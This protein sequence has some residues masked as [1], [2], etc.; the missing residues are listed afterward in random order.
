MAGGSAAGFVANVVAVVLWRCCCCSRTQGGALSSAPRRLRFHSC[1][2]YL[3]PLPF[4]GV[5]FWGFRAIDAHRTRWLPRRHMPASA[6]VSLDAPILQV[7]RLATHAGTQLE[8]TDSG[9]GR[10]LP[11]SPLP[12]AHAHA[13]W[14]NVD[15]TS[16]CVFA[17][18]LCVF[19]LDFSST[20]T[21]TP[22]CL[23]SGCH[24]GS[25]PP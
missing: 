6:R 4:L 7:R 19:V 24:F 9:R 23:G 21:H 5:C 14:N 16:T 18:T 15:N 10:S 2:F 17:I 25:M 8:G 13:P 20:H 3:L 1:M 11:P 22:E 12:D